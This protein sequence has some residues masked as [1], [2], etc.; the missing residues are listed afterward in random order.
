MVSKYAELCDTSI[1]T[2]QKFAGIVKTDLDE[3]VIEKLNDND[4]YD[5]EKKCFVVHLMGSHYTFR[6]RYPE[7]YD[8]FKPEDYENYKEHQRSTL[9]EYDNSILYNDYVVSEICHSFEKEEAIIIYFS[10]HGLDVFNSDENYVGHPRIVDYL[11]VA[12]GREIPFMIYASPEYQKNF[13]DKM[14][15]IKTTLSKSFRTDDVLYTIMDIMGVKFADNDDVNK[16]SL[17][18]N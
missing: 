4:L 15:Q 1:W 11:Y 10:D 17:F 14:H 16:Y 3:L 12:A 18:G 2:G 9:A 6:S 5:E 7:N 8:I 13:P